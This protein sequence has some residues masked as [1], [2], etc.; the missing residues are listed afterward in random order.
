MIGLLD[1]DFAGKDRPRS[2]VVFLQQ[3]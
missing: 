2:N 1:L 3:K